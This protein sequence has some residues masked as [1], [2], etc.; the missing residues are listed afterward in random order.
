MS[1]ASQR[2]PHAPHHQRRCLSCDIASKHL[3]SEFAVFFSSS[4]ELLLPCELSPVVCFSGQEAGGS[5]RSVTPL[6]L[7]PLPPRAELVYSTNAALPRLPETQIALS[8][9]F[10]TNHAFQP[11]LSIQTSLLCQI[12]K[13]TYLSFFYWDPLKQN[14]LCAP[15]SLRFWAVMRQGVGE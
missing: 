10:Y 14:L 4:V 1:T 2:D 7:V 8:C 11:L 6:F 3:A 13:G 5:V 12:W 15:F 9:T